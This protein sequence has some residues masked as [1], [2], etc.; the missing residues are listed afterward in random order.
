LRPYG[1]K[2]NERA[3]MTEVKNPPLF[4]LAG[5]RVYV[6]GHAGMVGSALV[7]RLMEEPCTLL[8]VDR[9][10]LDL[11]RQAETEQWIATARPDAVILAAAKVGGIAFNDNYPVDV[12]CDNLDI[13]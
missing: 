11:T 7:R 13:S 12:L 8:T 9:A 10:R 1:A 2:P 4:D 6:A 3:A 5:K